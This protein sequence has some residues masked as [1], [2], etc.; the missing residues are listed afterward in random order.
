MGKTLV[1]AEKPSVARDIAKVLGCSGKGEGCLVSDEYVVSWAIGHLVTLFEPEDYDPSY[2]K[3]SLKGLPIIP[4]EIKLKAAEKTKK[5]LNILKKLMNG[6]EVEN[7]V[8]ATDSGREGELIFRY[9]YSIAK[10]KKSFTRL[11]VSSMT[12]AAIREGFKNLKDGAFYDDLYRSAKCRSEADWLVGINASRAFSVKYDALLSVGRVQTPTLAVIVERQREIDAFVPN[13]YYEVTA[14]L[15][16]KGLDFKGKWFDPQNGGETKII[17]KEKADAIVQKAKDGGGNGVVESSGTEEKRQP[18]PL[19]Y[20]LTELQRDANKKF[21]FSAKKTLEIA[22]ELYE[23]RKLITYPRTDSRYLSGDI[24]PKFPV[25]LQKLS[26]CEKYAGFAAR[27]LALDKLPVTKRIVDASKVTDHHAIIPT[28]ANINLASLSAD[29]AK[30]Y[31]LAAR[32]F[33]A[34][35]YPNYIY[36]VTKTVVDING[37]KFLSK[38]RVVLQAGWTE[39][40]EQGD[41][42]QGKDEEENA[43]MPELKPADTADVLDVLAE[44]KRTKPPSPYTDAS[45]LSAMENA[46]RFTDDE[47]LKEKLRESGL[48][49]P[50]T[51]AAIIERLIQVGYVVRRGKTLVPTEK[52]I[53]LIEI[54]PFELKSPETTG[55]WEK[56]LSSISKGKMD[57]LKFM[58]SIERYVHYIITEA[59]KN[60]A[61]VV[62]PDEAKRR[63]GRAKSAGTKKSL[64]KCP[65]CGGSVYENSKAFSCSNWKTGCKFTLW[66]SAAESYGARLAPDVVE[67]LLSGGTVA[68]IEIIM[69]DTK[70]KRTADI[71]LKPDTTAKI[72]FVNVRDK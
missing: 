62:F 10:C 30:V 31:D 43:R 56:G 61:N 67:L 21:G 6:G 34:V 48:G 49:T 22:Q 33:L 53:K 35:F 57:S 52:G 64:G 45:L 66:K 55:K 71:V 8:C 26:V 36:N 65:I 39:L 17:E 27:L 9:I 46:G 63:T 29:E 1:I 24:I 12:D 5:Q 13:D 15:C 11:W 72:A 44:K 20:D 32:R 25:I 16:A 38:G 41:G 28:E 19:L 7:I 60:D 59:Q 68:G 42:A 50:A 14:L 18:P 4:A 70:E 54:V 3:W 69:P 37:E 40:Y 58:Q 51:R 47:E 2:K 23:K